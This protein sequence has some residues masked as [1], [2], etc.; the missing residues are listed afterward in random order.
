MEVGL[1]RRARLTNLHPLK[2]SCCP[3]S[4]PQRSFPAGGCNSWLGTDLVVW[5]Y[6]QP[7]V[8]IQTGRNQVL[9]SVHFPAPRMHSFRQRARQFR[10]EACTPQ[11]DY[12]ADQYHL[13]ILRAGVLWPGPLLTWAAHLAFWHQRWWRLQVEA[14]RACAFY[15]H[16]LRQHV[17]RGVSR[18]QYNR[19]EHGARLNRNIQVVFCPPPN[20]ACRCTQAIALKLF[21]QSAA[22][23]NHVHTRMLVFVNTEIFH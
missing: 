18:S 23:G 12:G 6:A 1:L 9:I 14:V 13:L 20:A 10:Y 3:H 22:G 11:L 4:E 7:T 15:W 19:A 21:R 8:L 5:G 17:L 2:I 16:S